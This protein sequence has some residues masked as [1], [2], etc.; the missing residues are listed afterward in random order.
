[1]KKPFIVIVLVLLLGCIAWLFLKEFKPEPSQNAGQQQEQQ[2]HEKEEVSPKDLVSARLVEEIEPTLLNEGSSSQSN[3]TIW[4]QGGFPKRLQ[5]ADIDMPLFF[6]GLI[7]EELKQ[8]ILA[9]LHLIFKHLI[10]HDYYKPRNTRSPDLGGQ[11]FSIK[12]G[13]QFNGKGA[14]WPD[15]L[16]GELMIIDKNGVNNV[17]LAKEVVE[18]YEKAWAARKA[19]PQKYESLESFIGWLNTAP[20]KE[21]KS[22]NPYWLFGYDGISD[23]HP[24]KA[25]EL[26]DTLLPRQRKDLRVR[27]PS[28][29]EFTYVDQEV[30]E[31]EGAIGQLPVGVTL[32]DGKYIDEEGIPQGQA[33]F[34]YDGKK[35]HIAFAPPGT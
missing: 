33:L 21:L 24:E 17:V 35:W 4:E 28:I 20:M 7:N 2:A 27:H 14:T 11:K 8:V 16:H 32:A 3:K 1:M 26:K 29:L 31:K 34:L 5:V 23:A 6:E 15:T 30:L 18:A 22:E 9:D 10:A 19:D 13:I 25:A 12:K